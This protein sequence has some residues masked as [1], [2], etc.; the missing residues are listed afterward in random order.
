MAKADSSST[1]PKPEAT[2][3]TRQTVLK[4]IDAKW[5]KFSKQDL[6]AARTGTMS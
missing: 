5:S 3:E 4:N 6:S 1:A 2:V